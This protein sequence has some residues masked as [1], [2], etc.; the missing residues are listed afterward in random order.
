[1]HTALD[2][3]A[4]PRAD[5]PPVHLEILAQRENTTQLEKSER[6]R[7]CIGND[8]PQLAVRYVTHF[9]ERT[10]PRSEQHFVFDDIADAREDG[11]IEQ[12][13]GDFDPGKCSDLCERS[14]PIPLI[15]HD[16]R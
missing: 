15:G 10:D 16:V 1:V 13:V 6:K 2:F 9:G 7:S 11:L 8:R 3:A 14:P 5:A 4:A 12:D